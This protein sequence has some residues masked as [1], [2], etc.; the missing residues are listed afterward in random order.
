M[1]KFT[2]LF[3]SVAMIIFSSSM[4]QEPVVHWRFANPV[5]YEDQGMCYFQFDVELSCDMAGTFHSDMQVYFNYNDLAFGQNIVL[6][7]N[8][9]HERLELMLGD[10]GGTNMY[11]IYGPQDNKPFRYAIL[12]EKVFPIA[13]PMFMNEVPML[14]TF[15]GFFQF[16]IMVQDQ[17]ELAGVEFVPSD[18]GIGIMDGGQYYLDATHP[19]AT[20]YGNPPDYAGVYENDLLTEPVMCGPQ[21]NEWTGAFDD[22]WFEDLNWSM[23]AVPAGEDVIIPDVGGKAPFPVIFGGSALVANMTITAGAQV[24]I[25]PTGDLTANGLTTIDGFLYIDSDASGASGSFIDLG[26]L[27]GT[28]TF[29]FDRYLTSAPNGTNDGWHYISSPV[30][31]TVTG[32]FIGYWVKEWQEANNIFFDL[33]PYPGPDCCPPSQFNVPINVMQGYSVKQ[34]VTYACCC[35]VG[36]VIMF[37]GDHMNMNCDPNCCPTWNQATAPALVGNINTGNLTSTITSS[38]NGVNAYPNWNLVGNPYPSGWDY[39]A[40]FFGTNWPAGLFDAIYYW[41]EANMQY[42]SYVLGIGNNGGDNY[43]PPTQGF[44]FETDGTVPSINLTFTNAERTHTGSG[45]YYKNEPKDIL[46]LEVNGQFSD[47][48][49]IRFME[50]ATAMHDGSYD[51]KKLF[52][53]SENVP[54]LWTKAGSVDLSINT[55]PATDMVPL[56][57]KGSEGNYTIEAV[58]N[59]F[60]TVFLEDLKTGVLHNLANPY[61]FYHS[62][63]DND[64]R[65]VIHFG[66]IAPDKA[67]NGISVYAS[68]NNIYINNADDLKANVEI[69]TVVGQ[70]V[71][72]ASLENGLNIVTM[73]DVNT[74]YIVKVTAENTLV[75]EK[76]YI[77]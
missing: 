10:V 34:D 39:D 77:R 19:A 64:G 6:N 40:F 58:D 61:S 72:E 71:Y 50:E 11:V 74:Y 15:G 13:N 53:L 54:S 2:I 47:Q 62:E 18:G 41:D 43:V 60:E 73:N 59:D 8:V 16:T 5:T 30:N 45:Y 22:N 65:F 36:P 76:V 3:F 70:K 12:T 48:T 51:A 28:G 7:N 14:P 46:R 69:F 66:T 44:F 57:F 67:E 9:T 4:A 1:R 21:V 31:N 49:T 75:T 23:G 29:Q 42:A 32:D 38:N 52:S 55:Q 56:Y 25:S 33:D 27:A 37:G 63:G 20:K 17:N 68:V 24:T 26:G 35:P